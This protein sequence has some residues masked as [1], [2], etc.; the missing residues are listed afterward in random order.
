MKITSMTITKGS[1]GNYIL[2]CSDGRTF[3][4]L[5]DEELLEKIKEILNEEIK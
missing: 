4:G 2:I 5:G 3:E 1:W